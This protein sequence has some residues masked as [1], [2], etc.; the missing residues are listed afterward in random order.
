MYVSPGTSPGGL[1][2]AIPS[3]VYIFK[4]SVNRLLKGGVV[5]KR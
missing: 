3:F 4:L 1:D 5:L 2:L